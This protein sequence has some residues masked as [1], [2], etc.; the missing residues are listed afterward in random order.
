MAGNQWG[1]TVTNYGSKTD[2]QT[3]IP[4]KISQKSVTS[5]QYDMLTCKLL[6]PGP[7]G[8][9]VEQPL[10]DAF[11]GLELREDINQNTVAGS[12]T[13]LDNSGKME[14][15]PIIGEEKLEL[16]VMTKGIEINQPDTIR[17][18]DHI[19]NTFRV[20]S[21]TN[22]KRTGERNIEFTLNFVTEEFILNL[23]KRVQKN[24]SGWQTST[25]AQSIFNE[26][27]SSPSSTALRFNPWNIDYTVGNYQIAIPNMTPF[28]SLNFLASRSVSLDYPN[29]SSYFF[30]E[31]F[32]DGFHFESLDKLMD[33]PTKATY[34]Y[35]PQNVG[36]LPGTNIY[37]AENPELISTFDVISNAKAGMYSNRLIAHDIIKM[38][39]SILDYNYV[40]TP[41]VNTTVS[42][43]PMAATITSPN[44]G[45]E[46]D[47]NWPAHQK[48]TVINDMFTHLETTDSQDMQ[49]GNRL[50]SDKMDLAQAQQN[51]FNPV[52]VNLFPT[53]YEPNMGEPN[54]VERWMI[55]RQ[56]QIRQMSNIKIRFDVAGDTS[57]HV[58]DLIEF[59]YPSF[60]SAGPGKPYDHQLYSGRYLV[61]SVTHS[62]TSNSFKTT[63][64][65]SKDSFKDQLEGQKGIPNLESVAY[66]V[67]PESGSIVGDE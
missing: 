53:N 50:T 24:F 51:K 63:L 34:V 47:K 30:Y 48:R 12:I 27:L 10:G 62:F 37:I 64:T 1:G 33:Q 23:K 58:G 11:M 59:K 44:V 25:I 36:E 32:T 29:S 42:P 54:H 56:S 18:S 31:T 67:N 19:E 28:E 40:P 6:V 20:I 2:L 41:A 43:P 16:Q 38:K 26:Y 39:Y 5:G 52:S 60:R 66:G 14:F 3:T 57:K 55:Q 17:K 45:F 7:G 46:K 22:I 15:W 9:I 65:L 61:T 13:L 4:E 49:I 35:A 21:A 8:T